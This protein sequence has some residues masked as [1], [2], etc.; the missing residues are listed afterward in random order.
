MK[1]ADGFGGETR[2]VPGLF[3]YLFHRPRA[4]FTLKKI[5]LRGGEVVDGERVEKPQFTMSSTAQTSFP[6]ALGPPST[7]GFPRWAATG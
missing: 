6:P 7:V 2:L 5:V 1:L 3:N 4:S